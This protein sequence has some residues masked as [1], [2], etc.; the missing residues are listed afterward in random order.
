MLRWNQTLHDQTQPCNLVSPTNFTYP[1]TNYNVPPM[2]PNRA[3]EAAV[4]RWTE[5]KDDLSAAGG[6]KY[7]GGV[8]LPDGRVVLVPSGA[9]HV[10]LYDPSADA[11][12]EGKDD[13]SA[14]GS[15]HKYRGGVLLPD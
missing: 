12:T 2:R 4:D 1:R 9:N 14:A 7:R 15:S 13:L 5:G 10:G 3:F 11:W 6:N 8:L